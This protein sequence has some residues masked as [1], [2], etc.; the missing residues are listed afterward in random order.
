[1]LLYA[2]KICGAMHVT[3]RFLQSLVGGFLVA[4]ISWSIRSKTSAEYSS[5]VGSPYRPQ[6]LS[7]G[8]YDNMLLIFIV[9][10]GFIWAMSVFSPE[11]LLSDEGYHWIQVAEFLEA[12]TSPQI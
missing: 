7:V 2:D 6:H 1:M 4:D 8:L 12:G 3:S 5:S 11:R 10:A 9:L